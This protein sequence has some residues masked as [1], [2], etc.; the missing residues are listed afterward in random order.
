MTVALAM[1]GHAIRRETAGRLAMLGAAALVLLA[2][3]VTDLVTGPSGMPLGKVL[4][5]FAAGPD[6]ADRGAATI[7]WQLRMPQTLTGVLVGA[8]LGVA[9]LV[10]QTILANPLASP[11]TLGFS[12]AAG[13][14]AALGIMFGG[15]LPLAV[16]IVVPASAFAMTLVA[17]CLIYA[18]ARAR[19]ASPEVLVLAGIAT[20]FFFQ[21]LQSLLQFL[22]APEVLQQIVFWLFGS[23]LKSS[24]TSVQAIF[25]ILCIAA[26]ILARDVWNLTALRLGEA[27][28]ASLG[29]DIDR[30]RR[31]CFALVA[32]LTAGAVSFTGT[33]GFIGLIA[34]HVARRMVGED[35]RF[36]LPVAAVL[37]AVLLVAASVIGKLIS[38]GA[39][40]PV[41]IIT[42]IAG[43]P[44]LLAVILKE[45]GR[46]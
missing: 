29:L 37:G 14:G 13:F 17:C 33:I 23:L 22:A 28:A 16:W 20:L 12:A 9:G 24:W 4:A 6:G 21:S 10:M 5:A 3:A 40:I 44:M 1:P 18:I 27:N 19:G 26:P 15:L 35:H 36:A 2:L 43:I 45:G 31:R 41:G 8:S 39:V 42:A 7:L 38:P 30:L 32:L 34:P 46:R 25:L 11:Y